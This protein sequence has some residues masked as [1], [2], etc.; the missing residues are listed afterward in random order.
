MRKLK[1]FLISLITLIFVGNI[2][3]QSKLGIGLT[4]GYNLSIAGLSNWYTGTIK[5]GGKIIFPSSESNELELEYAYSRFTDGSIAERMFAYKSIQKYAYVDLDGT[6]EFITDINGNFI[7]YDKIDKTKYPKAK[8]KNIDSLYSAG[9]SSFMTVNSITINSVI[10]F[11]RMS[12]LDSRFFITGGAGFYIYKHSVDSLLYG[13]R[14]IY[15]GKPVYM[16]PFVDSRVA[17]G[18]NIGG[19]Y[20]MEISKNISFDFRARYNLVIGELRP[21][22][23]Y[24]FKGKGF[25]TD[26]KNIGGLLKVFPIQYIDIV[27]SIKYYFQ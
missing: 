23:A 10:Y 7:P 26:D 24:G 11:D 22:E 25:A 3:A 4:G 17:L 15:K 16:K 6:K 5:F 21:L 1:L 27:T 12:F 18:I 19:G 20:N 2:Q 9:G 8:G 13:G 14:P